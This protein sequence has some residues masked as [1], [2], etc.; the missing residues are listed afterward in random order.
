MVAAV[1]SWV[2]VSFMDQVTAPATGAGNPGRIQVAVSSDLGRTFGVPFAVTATMADQFDPTVAIDTDGRTYLGWFDADPAG[3]HVRVATAPTPSGPYAVQAPLD[4]PVD[5]EI[6]DRPWIALAPDGTV[7]VAWVDVG[8]GAG[9]F[10]DRSDDRGAAFTRVFTRAPLGVRF[11]CLS[12]APDGTLYAAGSAAAT[13]EVVAA[14]SIDRGVSFTFARV[15]ALAPGTPGLDALVPT[16]AAT[17]TNGLVVAWRELRNTTSFDAD[18]KIAVSP[19]GQAFSPP[20]T[21]PAPDAMTTTGSPRP[22]VT[23]ASSGKIYV[24]FYARS[25]S[26]ADAVDQWGA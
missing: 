25:S 24:Q 6:D 2:V 20:I 23:V 8:A 22:T 26:G 19:D 21:M 11:G 7:Y 3:R 1:G 10:L 5:A 16:C 9:V 13:A 15:A 4:D 12:V 17:P 14:R 18:V